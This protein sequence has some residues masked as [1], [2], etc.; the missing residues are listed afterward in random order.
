MITS[1]HNFGIKTLILSSQIQCFFHI[2][3]IPNLIGHLTFHFE[4]IVPLW[5][6]G[7]PHVKCVFP[8]WA[9]RFQCGK[10]TF[11]YEVMCP[12]HIPICHHHVWHVIATSAPCH[13][14]IGMRVINMGPCQAPTINVTKK[15]TLEPLHHNLPALNSYP[16]WLD[17]QAW[18]RK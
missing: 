9:H 3:L 11:P 15:S 1:L 12:I 18:T 4:A 7:I 13:H 14:F 17:V 10:M 2:S 16:H 5:E 8:N 6:C